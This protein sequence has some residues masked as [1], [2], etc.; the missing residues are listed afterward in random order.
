MKK[1]FLAV[2]TIGLIAISGKFMSEA[3]TAPSYSATNAV[4]ENGLDTTISTGAFDTISTTADTITFFTKRKLDNRK[5]YCFLSN[6]SGTVNLASNLPAY[7]QALVY[8]NSDN[9]LYTTTIDSLVASGPEMVQLQVGSKI[10]GNGKWTLRAFCVDDPGTVIFGNTY[11]FDR[12][13]VTLYK[14]Y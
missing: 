1:I 14:N 6:L 7:I 9:L 13:P 12:R 8:D 2:L 10:L 5:E 11:L 4:Y 3:A